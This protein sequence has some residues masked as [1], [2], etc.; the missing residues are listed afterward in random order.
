M[1]SAVTLEHGCGLES[2]AR[3]AT[4]GTYEAVYKW[5]LKNRKGYFAH[6]YAPECKSALCEGRVYA[7]E[8]IWRGHVQKHIK[9]SFV[10]AF[11]S[12]VIHVHAFLAWED[13]HAR[14]IPPVCFVS[15]C[16]ASGFTD[17]GSYCDHVV[18]EHA[19]SETGEA[20]P[21]K[22]GVVPKAERKP[23]AKHQSHASSTATTT[24]STSTSTTSSTTSSAS[25][26]A[27]TAKTS[28]SSTTSH[29]SKSSNP[30]RRSS[31]SKQKGVMA[32]IDDKLIVAESTRLVRK[33][34]EMF[35]GVVL[36]HW[37]VYFQSRNPM[38]PGGV[39]VQGFLFQGKGLRAKKITVPLRWKSSIIS[40]VR[41]DGV[42]ETLSGSLYKLV[43][44][45]DE[46]AMLEYGFTQETINA[47]SKGFPHLW[48]EIL[49]SEWKRRR[50][51]ATSTSPPPPTAKGR[52]APPRPS[53]VQPQAQALDPFASLTTSATGPST[54][55][56]T[57]SNGDEWSPEELAALA[58]AQASVP[59]SVRNY[60][61]V[62]A[63]IVGTK[64]VEQCYSFVCAAPLAPRASS[65]SSALAPSTPLTKAQLDAA[66]SL[67]K[68][69]LLRNLTARDD[70]AHQ[71]DAFTSTPMRTS[72]GTALVPET[73]PS[74]IKE[75]DE[76]ERTAFY[77]Q[78]RRSAS[79]TSPSAPRRTNKKRA[80]D[81]RSHMDDHSDEDE[82]NAPPP[83]LTHVP[84]G[85]Q[86]SLDTY[87]H[88]TAKRVKS[89][90]GSRR[91]PSPQ[92]TTRS[93]QSHRRALNEDTA[94]A[95]TKLVAQVIG[96]AGQPDPDSDLDSDLDN[97]DDGQHDEYMFSDE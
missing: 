58:E 9:T 53:Q 91:S 72:L 87:V 93:S 96:S 69:Q 65:S 7:S 95:A 50:S 89:L 41:Q 94:A 79:P 25:T 15:A 3:A 36:T 13:A 38:A 47:F 18:A 43:G 6:G 67:K 55:T 24:T 4:E 35:N 22:R 61:S 92:S 20:K 19:S 56:T 8:Q 33:M 10:P 66:N 27:T 86:K 84:R 71:D 29:S 57:T 64:S 74:T 46:A 60:W 52:T 76:D 14:G 21:S 17:V 82:N 68:K 30:R 77:S 26:T 73:P 44:K 78:F 45:P 75:N 54:T 81:A 63:A 97:D 49:K 39:F 51:A 40:G 70:A 1:P 11:E 42:L 28:S 34:K 90:S 2:W 31:K 48:R 88:N 32:T 16:G 59:P 37:A 83:L 62:V 80:L 85:K 23:N 12:N 5:L